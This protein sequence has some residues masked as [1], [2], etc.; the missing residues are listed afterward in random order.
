MIC[1]NRSFSASDRLVGADGVESLLDEEPHLERVVNREDD[2]VAGGRPE[3]V[4]VGP[5]GPAADE[6]QPGGRR[7]IARGVKTGK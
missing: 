7:K 5:R 6:L 3:P 2:D 4:E 1:A